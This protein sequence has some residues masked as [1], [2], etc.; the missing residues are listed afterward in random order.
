MFSNKNIIF[1][2]A[3]TLHLLWAIMLTVSAE[4]LR[5]TGIDFV[6]SGTNSMEFTATM[7]FVASVFAFFSIFH[8][9]PR[10]I[11]NLF[12]FLPQQFLLLLSAFGAIMCMKNG[13]FADG[14]A[15]PRLFII[16]DQIP[17]V[18]IAI[19]HS[20]AMFKNYVLRRSFLS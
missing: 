16:A 9:F 20:V 18:L 4:P 5:T 7:F 11:G 13:Q 3:A 10:R 6:F 15:R 2:Y 1:L 19:L 8:V 14:E 17:I 12:M